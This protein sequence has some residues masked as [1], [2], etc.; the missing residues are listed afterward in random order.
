MLDLECWRWFCYAPFEVFFMARH[1]YILTCIHTNT[2]TYITYTHNSLQIPNIAPCFA[3]E[4]RDERWTCRFWHIFTIFC[5][6]PISTHTYLAI[7]EFPPFTFLA[8]FRSKTLFHLFFFFCCWRIKCWKTALTSFPSPW[9]PWHTGSKVSLVVLIVCPF[10]IVLVSTPVPSD[11]WHA[12]LF[13]TTASNNLRCGL[14]NH[15]YNNK[16]HKKQ[17]DNLKQTAKLFK[18]R[19]DQ[20]YLRCNILCRTSAWYQKSTIN[21]VSSKFHL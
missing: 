6:T 14:Y 9:L 4:A 15:N 5:K 13:R 19:L 21:Y 12:K 10:G 20:N 7:F 18:G 2:H 8:Q 11:F 17:K 1:T 3:Y 16:N